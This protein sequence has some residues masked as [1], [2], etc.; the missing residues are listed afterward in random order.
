MTLICFVYCSTGFAGHIENISQT[1]CTNSSRSWVLLLQLMLPVLFFVTNIS[2]ALQAP[3]Q[4]TKPMLFP[5]QTYCYIGFIMHT[6]LPFAHRSFIC[7]NNEN[8]QPEGYLSQVLIYRLL[9]HIRCPEFDCPIIA[10]SG[11]S[12]RSIR[13]DASTHNFP[14]MPCH[15]LQQ[16]MIP[17]RPQL[18]NAIKASREHIVAIIGI[19]T[20]LHRAMHCDCNIC[21]QTCVHLTGLY[22]LRCCLQTA[23]PQVACSAIV[24]GAPISLVYSCCQQQGSNKMLMLHTAVA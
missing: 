12:T 18:G 22:K 9:I 14:F 20:H 16:I 24:L 15:C 7:M 21:G 6:A 17:A 1:G 3:R 8:Q 2:T 23:T 10:N 5:C 13:A 11:N 19:I 4:L